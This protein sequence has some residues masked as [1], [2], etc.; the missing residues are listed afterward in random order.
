MTESFDLTTEPWIRVRTRDGALDEVSLREV[1]ARAHEIIAITGELSTQDVAILRLLLAILR[2]AH[3]DEH[4]TD[5]WGVLW[6]RGS[7]DPEP[8]SRYLD[9]L[10]DR[11]DLLHPLAPFYQVAGLATPKGAMTE[12]A[13]LIAD[14]PPGHP[15]FTTRTGSALDSMSFAEAAR[16]LV[17]CQAFDPSG[18]KSGAVGDDRVKGGKGYPI[19]VAWCGWLGLVIV[20]GSTL[21]ETLLLNLPIGRRDSNPATDLP[22]WERPAQGAAIEARHEVPAGPADLLTWQSRRIRIGHDGTH[23]TAVLIANGDALHPRN[24]FGEEFMTSWRLS[25]A[26]MKSL[27]TNEQV[28]M[29]RG[30]PPDRAVWR[31]L[32]GLLAEGQAAGTGRPGRWLDWLGELR[33][34]E[35]LPEDALVRLR[36]VAMQY[37]SNNSVTDDIGDDVLPLSV[38]VLVSRQLRTLAVDAVRDVDHAVAALGAFAAELAEAAGASGDTLSDSRS[39]ARE[40]GYASVDQPYRSWLRTVEPGIDH[41]AARIEWQRR[42]RAVIGNL[43]G[44]LVRDASPAAWVGRE[45]ERGSGTVYLDASVAESKFYRD[46]RKALGAALMEPAEGGLT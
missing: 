24:R 22:V 4:G 40:V 29:P 2:R 11:F 30:H 25:E 7:F 32:A 23:A 3:S 8:I 19:G 26:Q 41:D 10:A 15:Y 36:A 20:E 14:V 46:L 43:A 39:L 5:A 38:A 17:H 13:R 6:R 12:L 1:F 35:V 18:I 34:D 21:F 44:E 28:F 31:G 45:V 42:V 33:E 37:G 16:W 27:G 9:R